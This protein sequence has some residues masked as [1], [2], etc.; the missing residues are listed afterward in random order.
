MAVVPVALGR[1]RWRDCLESR[2]SRLIWV[3]AG[4]LSEKKMQTTEP[5]WVLQNQRRGV[6]CIK[7]SKINVYL[8]SAIYI[9][10]LKTLQISDRF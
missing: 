7:A 6:G 9:K 1:L 8:G 3:T 10:S 2:S 5:S 4:P